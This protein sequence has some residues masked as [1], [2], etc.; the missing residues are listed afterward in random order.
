MQVKSYIKEH[1]KE[2]TPTAYIQYVFQEIQIN[3]ELI[4]LFLKA[5]LIMFIVGDVNSALLVKEV[6]M[7]LACLVYDKII[8]KDDAKSNLT[9]NKIHNKT[10]T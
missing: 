3:E 5:I 7:L 9:H 6:Y 8:H 4:A 1:K 2:L 10:H